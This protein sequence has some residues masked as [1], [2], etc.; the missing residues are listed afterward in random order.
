MAKKLMCCFLTVFLLFSSKVDAHENSKPIEQANTNHFSCKEFINYHGEIVTLYPT[1]DYP[2]LKLEE[3]KN[4]TLISLL[5]EKYNLSPL[6]NTNWDQYY[7]SMCLAM[8]DETLSSSFNEENN[9]FIE[10]RNFFDI[11]ENAFQNSEIKTALS[12]SLATDSVSINNVNIIYSFP[13]SY[14]DNHRKNKIR[15]DYVYKGFDSTQG[16]NYADL[17]ATSPNVT[18]YPRYSKDCTNFASQILD[19]GGARQSN[20][21]NEY[22]G[23]WHT[24]RVN[25]RNKI[26]S[27]S[28]SWR[29]ADTFAKYMGVGYTT[30]DNNSFCDNLRVGDFIGLDFNNDGDWNHMGFVTG[31]KLSQHAYRVAQH[32]SNYHKWTY[33]SGNNWASQGSKGS[34]YGRI[35]R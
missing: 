6:T 4:T 8:D 5:K 14:H 7:N 12:K 15:L 19:R 21:G 35:G 16:I 17:N 18:D 25:G 11:Y 29:V 20:T 13:Q 27:T 22:S 32:T 30:C 10:L 3:I 24:Y 9:E 28:R 34:K 2:E 31:I 23:W 33:E 1:Y 26:H